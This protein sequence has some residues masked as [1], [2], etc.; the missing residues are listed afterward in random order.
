MNQDKIAQVFELLLDCDQDVFLHNDYLSDLERAVI[1]NDYERV[2]LFISSGYSIYYDNRLCSGYLDRKYKIHPT[3]CYKKLCHRTAVYYALVNNFI[4][5]KSIYNILK[6]LENN[7]NNISSLIDVFK[8]LECGCK[9]VYENDIKYDDN[10]MNYSLV[11]GKLEEHMD[12][13]IELI[14][15]T[16]ATL[17]S[18]IQRLNGFDCL[19]NYDEQVD[20][21]K[22]S[23]YYDWYKLNVKIINLLLNQQSYELYKYEL[24]NNPSNVINIIEENYNKQFADIN[25][26]NAYDKTNVLTLTIKHQ[27]SPGLILK[28]LNTNAELSSVTNSLIGEIMSL[29]NLEITELLIRKC[30]RDQLCQPCNVFD[31]L[32]NKQFDLDRKMDM[33]RELVEKK[34]I[35]INKNLFRTLL[36]NIDSKDILPII[37]EDDEIKAVVDVYDIEHAI[38]LKKHVE[39]DC[40]FKFRPD[41]VNAS[42]CLHVYLSETIYDDAQTLE[43]LNTI[44]KSKPKSDIILNGMNIIHLTADKNRV[45]TL[46]LLLNNGYGEII[47][48]AD[49]GENTAIH[50]ALKKDYYDIARM[51]ITYDAKIL[52]TPDSSDRTPLVLALST[53]NPTKYIKDMLN[54]GSQYIN[55]NYIDKN[56]EYFLGHLIKTDKI[57]YNAKT[58]IANMIIDSDIKLDLLG[59]N[60]KDSKPLVVKA[61]EH[62]LYDIVLHITNKL[63]KLG[64]LE[65]GTN[66]IEDILDRSYPNVTAKDTSYNFYPLVLIYLKH[67]RKTKLNATTYYQSLLIILL[68]SVIALIL[69]SSYYPN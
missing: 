22:L 6:K 1:V 49:R 14:G 67:G 12:P 8:I 53:K 15:T 19:H 51:L 59:V 21:S 24:L 42:C 5:Y 61:V 43:V 38:K 7:N 13:I 25:Y 9:S 4:C 65:T 44:L 32:L 57:Q 68:N 47:H 29:N 16:Q 62:D 17:T 52:D 56:G 46:K 10:F 45:E 11:R 35:S 37:M 60:S 23:Y 18:K 34:C 48:A 20:V 41:L 3:S 40:I 58:E 63:I 28:L 69:A 2:N 39:L 31:Q 50:I 36:N 66:V 64:K 30:T 26:I 54:Y 55:I 27:G 33:L